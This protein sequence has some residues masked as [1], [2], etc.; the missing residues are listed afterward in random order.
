MKCLI[1]S[2]A[3]L[4]IVFGVLS[5]KAEEPGEKPQELKGISLPASEIS[6][7]IP[8][9]AD[10]GFQGNGIVRSPYSAPLLANEANREGE[11]SYG[12]DPRRAPLLV[13]W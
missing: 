3:F 10:C 13:K 9:S 1:K 4:V 12:S 2:F 5:V 7:S 6:G 8:V 11:D